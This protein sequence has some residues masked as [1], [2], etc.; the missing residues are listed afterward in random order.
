MSILYPKS[1]I[2]VGATRKKGNFVSLGMTL[3]LQESAKN[4]A[5][6][7]LYLINPGAEKYSQ[8][9]CD[10]AVLPHE[11]GIWLPD[12]PSLPEKDQYDAA[13]V[14]VKAELVPQTIRELNQ[15]N[16]KTILVYSSGFEEAGNHE[17]TEELIA[18]LDEGPAVMFGPNIQ[19]G[20]VNTLGGHVGLMFVPTSL[21]PDCGNVSIVSQS[22][23]VL[24]RT[25]DQTYKGNLRMGMNLG[26]RNGV[27]LDDM[28]DLWEK[29]EQTEVAGFHLE[30]FGLGEG[31]YF[32]RALK[33][34]NM[35]KVVYVSSGQHEAGRKSRELHSAA[36]GTKEGIIRSA[37][38][39]AGAIIAEDGREFITYLNA[40][41][42]AEQLGY[43]S[44]SD[45]L[46]IVSPGGG[47]GVEAASVRTDLVYMRDPGF[48]EKIG[49]IISDVNKPGNP[50]D[51]GMNT[52]KETVVNAVRTS[53]E[54]GA[55]YVVIN[56]GTERF[57]PHPLE[58]AN[59]VMA[60]KYIAENIRQLM[61]K[62][63]KMVVAAH[64]GR[65]EMY[66]ELSKANIPLAPT[67]QAAMKTANAL[68]Q[69]YK[70]NQ[71]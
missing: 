25:I 58:K 19:G 59:Q 57:Y 7:E 69:H 21:P 41:S 43:D 45:K 27:G 11:P 48:L 33:R 70:A 62:H 49:S 55:D 22:G 3:S 4:V 15:K 37:L 61:D 23:S 9:K 50:V 64:E 12:V 39:Q 24:L 26:N 14:A 35:P 51:I 40:F 2:A 53:L 5:G 38:D 52:S 1:I 28:L 63:K 6:T 20:V 56:L 71:K 66:Q 13:I 47:E 8:P 32:V 68:H 46:V 17:L 65:G 30:G 31:E 29:D 67:P 18:A 44:R 42:A 16:V 34:T 54:E 10:G 60:P 36:Y